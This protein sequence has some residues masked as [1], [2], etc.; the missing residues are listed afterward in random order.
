MIRRKYQTGITLLEMMLVF[1]IMAAAFMI[2]VR[3]IF[4]FQ[5]QARESQLYAN[6]NQLF[7]AT[8]GFYNANCRQALLD[9]NGTS[10]SPGELDPEVRG[11]APTYAISVTRDLLTPGFLISWQPKNPLLDNTLVPDQGYFVQ[12]NR[13]TLPNGSDPA[14]GVVACTG[15]S[16]SV[17]DSSVELALDPTI[18]NPNP[19]ARGNAVTWIIQVGVKLSTKFTS[20]QWTQIKNDLNA[21]CISTLSGNGVAQCTPTPAANG[22]LVWTRHPSFYTDNITSDFWLSDPYAREFKMQYTNDGMGALSGVNT[23]KNWYNA[24]NYLCGG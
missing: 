4:Q 20:A 19:S 14:A 22:Y 9:S 8:A 17:C 16:P 11:S 24:L 6:V 12:F 10:Q 18:P 21:Q 15:N 1:A 23:G 7:K 2:G 3:F 5:F 13:V